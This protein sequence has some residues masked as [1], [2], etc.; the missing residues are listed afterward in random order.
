MNRPLHTGFFVK[1]W[2]RMFGSL[3]D[4]PCRCVRCCQ[5]AGQ[6]EHDQ[7]LKVDKPDYSVLLR[8]AFWINPKAFR[9]ADAA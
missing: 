3:N 7:W 6:R 1:T 5:A 9:N 4:K 2:D 8:P